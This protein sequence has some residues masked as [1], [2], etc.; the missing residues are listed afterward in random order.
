MTD[1][2]KMM[3]FLTYFTID[4]KNKHDDAADALA[5]LAIYVAGQMSCQI[6]VMK[7]IF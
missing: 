2:N 3:K 7:P 6:E 4:G 5:M 1:Y